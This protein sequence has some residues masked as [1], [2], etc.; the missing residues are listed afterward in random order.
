MRVFITIFLVTLG[1]ALAHAQSRPNTLR[2]TCGQASNLV[3]FRGTIVLGTGPDIYDRFVT[4]CNFCFNFQY[5][6]PTWVQTADSAQCFVGYRCD[7]QTS[8]RF[9]PSC[10]VTE[11]RGP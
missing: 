4:S 7:S 9:Y 6:I 8:G 3:Q 5:L 1:A 11:Y 10:G 2:M